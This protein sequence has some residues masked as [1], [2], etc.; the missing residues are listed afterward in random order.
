MSK[1]TALGTFCKILITP[2]RGIRLLWVRE[3]TVTPLT[4]AYHQTRISSRGE[5]CQGVYM[6]LHIRLRIFF[7]APDFKERFF[8]I[9]GE[10]REFHPIAF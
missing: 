7:F 8:R 9:T 5:R 6:L 10:S 2:G 1:T 4:E 3:K